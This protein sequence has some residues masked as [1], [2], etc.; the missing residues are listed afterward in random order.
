MPTETLGYVEME[1]TCGKCGTRNRGMDRACVSCG[2]PMPADQK[3]ERPAEGALIK[4][5]AKVEAAKKGADV[6]CPYCGARNPADAKVCHQ[7][8]GDLTK[9]QKREAGAVIGAHVEARVEPVPCPS[10]S[11][12]NAPDAARCISCGR[13]LGTA[14]PIVQPVAAPA[15][16]PAATAAPGSAFMR[17]VGLAI[18]AGFLLLC[19]LAG[20]WYFTQTTTTTDTPATVSAVSWERIVAIEEQ[21]RV[22]R[23]AWGDRVPDDGTIKQCELKPREMLSA[24]DPGRKSEKICGTP[25]EV[26]LGNGASEVRQDCQYQIYDDWCEYTQLDW[27]V[28]DRV[29]ASGSDLQPEWPALNLA[30]GQREGGHSETYVVVFSADSRQFEY[31][32]ADASAFAEFEPG[33]AWLLKVDGFGNIDALSPAP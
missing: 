18:G 27:Q 12:P 2:A 9:G 32:V 4:D 24:P 30:S 20:I 3:F 15:A 7:C 33:S 25:Y 17:W 28:A 21:V 23:S 13:P 22:T 10:C 6:H 29:A 1:W 8:Q 11:T 14:T 5:E 26:D 19:V 31:S 16:Q